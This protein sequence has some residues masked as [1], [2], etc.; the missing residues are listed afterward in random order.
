MEIPFIVIIV[1]LSFIVINIVYHIKG[2]R[3]FVMNIRMYVENKTGHGE[4]CMMG[5]LF[6]SSVPI[7]RKLNS[8]AIVHKQTVLTE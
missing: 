4:D 6:S 2:R 1:E 8:V 3:R 5:S 7:K